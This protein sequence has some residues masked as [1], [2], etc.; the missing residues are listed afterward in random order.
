[1]THAAYKNLMT[2]FCP[3]LVQNENA[4]TC[5]PLNGLSHTEG[6]DRL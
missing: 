2:V 3:S 1:L 5:L 4:R 6:E